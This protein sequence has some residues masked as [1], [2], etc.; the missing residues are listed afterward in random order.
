MLFWRKTVKQTDPALAAQEF[1]DIINRA[2]EQAK[3]DHVPWRQI[4]QLLSAAADNERMRWVMT[5]PIG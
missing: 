3:E 1:R 2:I 5:A 4:A